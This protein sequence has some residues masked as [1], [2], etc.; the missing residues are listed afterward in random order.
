MSCLSPDISASLFAITPASIERAGEPGAR[1]ISG[2]L[3]SACTLLCSSSILSSLSERSN[4][5][6]VIRALYCFRVA[7]S[8][9]EVVEEDGAVKLLLQSLF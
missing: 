7:A 5:R 4:S 3:P 9:E 8:L 6:L 1:G 2:L